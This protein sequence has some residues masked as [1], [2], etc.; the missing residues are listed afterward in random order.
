MEKVVEEQTD[1]QVHLH[2]PGENTKQTYK[3]IMLGSFYDKEPF[4]QSIS[5][6][7]KP[8]SW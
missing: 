7:I 1:G 4:S 8:T 2:G 5:Q 6:S 3:N